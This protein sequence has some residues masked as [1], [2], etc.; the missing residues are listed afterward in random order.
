MKFCL[1]INNVIVEG[2]KD[3]PQNTENISNFNLLGLEE[4]K[5]Y[6]WLPYRLVSNKSNDKIL[7]S[8]NIEILE[9]EVVETEIYR[10]LTIQEIEEKQ[11][12]ILQRKWNQVRQKRNGLLRDCDWTQLDD[13][14]VTKTTWL[15]YR[16]QLRNLPQNFSDPDSVIWPQPPI[17]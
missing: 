9:N 5:Q 11:N 1:V 17:N 16:E 7:V 10:D 12:I 3:L 4:L 13:S 6:G 8:K 2:P 14:P 15:S